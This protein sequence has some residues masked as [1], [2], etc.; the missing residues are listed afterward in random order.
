MNSPQHHHDCKHCIFLGRIGTAD[1]YKCDAPSGAS[2]ILRY[3]SEGG[4]YYSKADFQNTKERELRRQIGGGNDL[5]YSRITLIHL[6]ATG[7]T[8]LMGKVS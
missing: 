8:N 6:C 4:D 7:I 2:Y 3:S 5:Y 1:A